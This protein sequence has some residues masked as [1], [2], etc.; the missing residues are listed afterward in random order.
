MGPCV[1]QALRLVLRPEG[2]YVQELL[3]QELSAA[4]DAAG[5]AVLSRGAAAVLQSAAAV[6]TL[7]IVETLGPLRAIVLPLPTPPEILSRLAPV[8][9]SH[10]DDV[11]C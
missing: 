10:T 5:R 9:R 3:M 11:E 6:G 2:S 8:S 4:V 7:A 1:A